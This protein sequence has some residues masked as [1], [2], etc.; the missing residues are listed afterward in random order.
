MV[1]DGVFLLILGRVCVFLQVQGSSESILDLEEFAFVV[2][3]SSSPFF[4]LG[5]GIF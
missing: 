5:A 1:F 3:Q 4:F 2:V